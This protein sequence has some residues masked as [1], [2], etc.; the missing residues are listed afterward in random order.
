M[1]ICRWL[2]VGIVILATE[3]STSARAD[4]YWDTNGTTPGSTDTPPDAPG[5]WDGATQNWSTD[6]H[7]ASPTQSWTA[8]ELAVFSAGGDAGDTFT[9]TVS[10][11][12][13]ASGIR[14]EDGTVTLSGGAINLT[15][16]G[17]ITGPSSFSAATIDSAIGGAVG[18]TLLGNGT[19]TFSGTISGPGKLRRV[20]AGGTS[21]LAADNTY[22]GGTEVSGGTLSASGASASFGA[23]N[24][25]VTGGTLSIASGVAN[26]ID[27][28]ATLSISGA[29]IVNLGE[30]VND[31]IAAL[32]LDGTPG[33][34]GTYGSSMS[35]ADY[36]FDQW[37]SGT[38]IVTISTAV[39]AGDY[40]DDGKV[41][42]ADY[43][44]WRKNE[45][46]INVLPNDN[47]IGGTVGAAHFNLWRA[48]FGTTADGAA[49]VAHFP[50]QSTVPEPV[51]LVLLTIATTGLTMI[52]RT[53]PVSKSA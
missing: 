46:T 34:P 2:I 44:I 40:N 10:G 8:G 9:V 24:I 52:S 21:I 13:Y 35:I 14:F 51:S 5:T 29:G 27:D 30:G 17:T 3:L 43:L 12:Q 25:T 23:G 49:A 16:A 19:Q 39:L 31:L 1:S 18:L 7:G 4:L 20:T 26:A 47:E 36:Q 22:S 28:M 38:G 45:G 48:N 42:A 11:T 32:T 6:S 37:F 41:D 50:P 33:V 53:R 15:S